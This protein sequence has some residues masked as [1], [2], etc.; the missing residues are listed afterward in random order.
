MSSKLPPDVKLAQ[1]L[2]VAV[3]TAVAL[4]TPGFVLYLALVF[5]LTPPGSNFAASA[6]WYGF[7]L[8]AFGA[9]AYGFVNPRWPRKLL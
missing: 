2:I 6:L 5:N 9:V 1:R 7:L 4:I 3:A 8:C